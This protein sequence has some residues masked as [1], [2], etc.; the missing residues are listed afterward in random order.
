[1]KIQTRVIFIPL[2]MFSQPLMA[3]L[4]QRCMFLF[5]YAWYGYEALLVRKIFSMK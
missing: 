3:G 5:A 2:L 4:L 1:M